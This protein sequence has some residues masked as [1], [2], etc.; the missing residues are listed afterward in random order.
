M[1][2]QKTLSNLGSF[3]LLRNKDFGDLDPPIPPLS[4]IPSESPPAE[5][6]NFSGGAPKNDHD[7]FLFF[8]F[9]FGLTETSIFDP[10]A[11]ENR[12]FH[13]LNSILERFLW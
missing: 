11:R 13:T 9:G 4:E 1:N 10:Q 12:C 7:A 8:M 3:D 6:K 5:H 2:T